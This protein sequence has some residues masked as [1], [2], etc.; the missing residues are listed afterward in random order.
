MKIL[1]LKQKFFKRRN[2][3]FSKYKSH[4]LQIEICSL[5]LDIS[6]LKLEE[7][8]SDKKVNVSNIKYKQIPVQK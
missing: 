7:E 8:I 1:F 4:V 5:E 2:F 6:G 3:W